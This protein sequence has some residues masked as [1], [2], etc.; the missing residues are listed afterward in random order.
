[1]SE[2]TWETYCVEYS[3]DGKQWS[4]DICATSFEDAAKRV[5]ALQLG[6]VLKVLGSRPAEDMKGGLQ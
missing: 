3:Y 2:S 4:V 6:T 1:M 5:K